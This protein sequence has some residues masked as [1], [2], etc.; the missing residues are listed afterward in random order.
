MTVPTHDERATAVAPEAPDVP[1]PGAESP[2][3][4]VAVTHDTA[5]APS[6]P[7]GPALERSITIA[8]GPGAGDVPAR[9]IAALGDRGLNAARRD[10]LT[11]LERRATKRVRDVLRTL[12]A[13]DEALDRLEADRRSR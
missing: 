7:S 8:C 4:A 2:L 13:I 5:A 9:L 11:T 3:V 1:R 6:G 12:D 10:A